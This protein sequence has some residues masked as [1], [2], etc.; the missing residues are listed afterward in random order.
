MKNSSTLRQKFQQLSQS[1][2][3][4]HFIAIFCAL[5]GTLGLAQLLK[6]NVVNPTTITNN[7]LL[8]FVLFG[9]ALYYLRASLPP[10][11]QLI[12]CVIF[13]FFLST[14]LILGAQLEFYSNIVWNFVTLLKIS[15]LCFMIYPFIALI[16]QYLASQKRSNFVPRTKHFYIAFACVFGATLIIWA[17]L[18]PGVFTYDMATQNEQ[19]S[20]GVI[21]SHWSL[22]YGYLFAGFLDLGKAIFG[23]YEAGMAIAMFVQ[24]CF[25]CYVEAKLIVFAGRI[26]RSKIIYVLSILFFIC[27]PFFGVLAI[28]SAQDVLFAGLFALVVIEL[29]QLTYSHPTQ[30]ISKFTLIKIA[31]FSVLMC[32]ARNNGVYALL[33][34]LLFV[35]FFYRRPR[36]S[37]IITLAISVGVVFLYTGPVLSFFHVEKSDTIQ[38][39]SSIPSQQLARS[40]FSNPTSFSEEDQKTLA[41]FYNIDGDFQLYQQYPL[42]SDF[43]K[44]SLNAEFTSSNLGKYLGFW[45]KIGLKNPD[46][47]IEAFLLNSFGFWY[48]NKDYYDNRLK[49]GFMNYPGVAMTEASYVRDTRP[50][51]KPVSSHHAFPSIAAKLEGFIFDNGWMKIPLLSTLCAIGTYSLLL[52]FTIGYLIAYKRYNLLM[53]LSL[54]FGF[55]ITLLLSP[56]A[57]FRYAYPMIMLVPIFLAFLYRGSDKPNTYTTQTTDDASLPRR[58]KSRR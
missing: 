42:V 31:V 33:V 4:H 9:L 51:M 20:L 47:Y 36:K 26:S 48:P 38:E 39:I 28:S 44:G 22:L 27:V 15:T 45:A 16:S 10:K 37:L 41:E 6:F 46:N 19:I 1:V 5:L 25:I 23:N 35:I 8:F 55:F 12:F 49:L 30:N 11:R 13:S 24:A 58:S 3:F 18:F 52:L 40:Y 57:I 50:A 7:F 54:V 2:Y 21:T 53:P 34:L 29:T 32:A 56:V 17:L 14:V 43:T